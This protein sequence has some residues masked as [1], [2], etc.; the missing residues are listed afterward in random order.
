MEFD[1]L[2]SVGTLFLSEGVR[3]LHYGINIKN[4]GYMYIIFV[5]ILSRIFTVSEVPYIY[6]LLQCAKPYFRKFLRF[7]LSYFIAVSSAMINF[8]SNFLRLIYY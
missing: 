3:N 1:F 6:N 5:Y 4:A 2:F 7:L 8:S